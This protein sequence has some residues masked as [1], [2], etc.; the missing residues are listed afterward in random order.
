MLAWRGERKLVTVEEMEIHLSTG[1]TLSLSASLAR[2]CSLLPKISR[3]RVVPSHLSTELAQTKF[4]F[5]SSISPSNITI[6]ASQVTTAKYMIN[7]LYRPIQNVA[8]NNANN[9]PLGSLAESSIWYIRL[10]C[11]VL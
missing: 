1:A 3:L 7:H 8:S 9:Q 6:Q 10:R 4:W 5:P 2:L 11:L